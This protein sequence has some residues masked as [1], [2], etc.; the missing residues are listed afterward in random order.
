MARRKQVYEGKAKILYEGPEPG[1]LIVHYKDD[2]TASNAQKKAVID[3]KVQ[4]AQSGKTFDNVS[5]RDG[6]I[7]IQVAE[8]DA[9]DIDL[10]VAAARR[11]FEDGTWRNM[12]YREKKRVLFRL[13]DLMDRDREQLAVGV[14]EHFQGQRRAALGQGV[15]ARHQAGRHIVGP[16]TVHH[17]TG[18]VT[19]R[20]LRG[21]N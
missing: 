13:A 4:A 19:Y 12:H 16:E 20:C 8:G 1:T 7:I 10:A 18:V 5:P 17:G 11:A 6:R 2:A 3:G 21:E 14:V 9:A 15:E